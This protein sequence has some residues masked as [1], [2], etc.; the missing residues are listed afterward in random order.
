MSNPQEIDLV[1]RMSV[2]RGTLTNSS[3]STVWVII[4][5]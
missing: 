1:N 5:I 2:G 3:W 4:I